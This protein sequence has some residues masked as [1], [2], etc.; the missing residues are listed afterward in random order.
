MIKGSVESELEAA[1]VRA[2]RVPTL[3]KGRRCRRVPTLPKEEALS[4]GTL[5]KSTLSNEKIARLG[6]ELYERDIRPHF[7]AAHVGEYMAIDVDSGG[8]ALAD[9]LGVAA[10]SLRAAHPDA[11]NVWLLRVGYNAVWGHGARP[12]R[13]AP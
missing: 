12:S 7:A 9:D 3:P 6:K 8:W 4:P 2:H 11:V 13:R 5:E 10:A 1:S